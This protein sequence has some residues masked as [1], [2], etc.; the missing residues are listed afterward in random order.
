MTDAGLVSGDELFVPARNV[1]V[2]AGIDVRDDALGE[3]QF[4]GADHGEVEKEYSGD[5]G[6]G[7]DATRKPWQV[8]RCVAGKGL[9]VENDVG[10]LE[11]ALAGGMP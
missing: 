9:V 3:E 5:G 10:D 2:A 11:Q 6:G 8:H 1:R 4:D 7:A